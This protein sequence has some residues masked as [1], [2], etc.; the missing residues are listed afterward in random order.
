MEVEFTPRDLCAIIRAC[1]KGRVARLDLRDLH[2]VFGGGGCKEQAS[3]VIAE[4][5]VKNPWLG[6]K[7][8]LDL[9]I[10]NVSQHINTTSDTSVLLSDDDKEDLKELLRQDML[11]TDAVAYEDAMIDEALKS[12]AII[13]EG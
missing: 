9:P 4:G 3:S 8:S 5:V 6:L 10:D 13:E 2:V 12:Q 1:D 7:P 11:A